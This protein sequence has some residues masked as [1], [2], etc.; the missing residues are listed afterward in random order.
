M[1]R[2]LTIV[3]FILLCFSL[4]SCAVIEALR[5]SITGDIIDPVDGFSRGEEYTFIYK[6]NKYILIQEINGDCEV[7]ITEED[8][9]LGSTSNFPFFPDSR[10]YA[11]KDENPSFITGTN[12]TTMEGSCVYLREDL[13]SKGIVYALNDSSFEFEF[14]SA[15]VKT[16]KVDYDIHVSRKKYTKIEIVDFYMKEIPIIKTCKRIY[17]IN[18]KWYHIETD[19]AYQLSEEFVFQLRENGTIN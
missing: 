5:Y 9:L 12:S 15:F 2:I 14:T 1:K 16:D 19:V 8:I 6:G 7:D 3:I 4:T 18:N 10:Y 17:L 11:S 13:Y